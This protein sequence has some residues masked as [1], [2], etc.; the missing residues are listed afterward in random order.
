MYMDVAL[1]DLSL[2]EAPA[3]GTADAEPAKEDAAGAYSQ[4]QLLNH[5]DQC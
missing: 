5:F 4:D 2:A 3:E 1:S